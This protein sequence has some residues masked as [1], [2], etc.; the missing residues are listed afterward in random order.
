MSA[1]HKFERREVIQILLKRPAASET[2][3]Y[4]NH[5]FCGSAWM[6]KMSRTD[7]FR[8]RE[9]CVAFSAPQDQCVFPSLPLLLPAY[10]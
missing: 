7:Y 2:R 8:L 1:E 5:F 4:F 3:Q 10:Q 9:A 6:F